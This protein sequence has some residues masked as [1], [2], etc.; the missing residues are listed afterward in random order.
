MH[1]AIFQH[2]AHNIV[3]NAHFTQMA[4][5]PVRGSRMGFMVNLINYIC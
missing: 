3:H 4:V 5:I 2:Y 1:Y